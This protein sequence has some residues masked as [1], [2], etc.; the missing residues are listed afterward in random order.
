MKL[1]LKRRHCHLLTLLP[2]RKMMMRKFDIFLDLLFCLLSIFWICFSTMIG[3]FSF[4]YIGVLVKTIWSPVAFL[5]VINRVNV[6]FLNYIYTTIILY[7]TTKSDRWLYIYTTI[8]LY[9]T[10]EWWSLWLHWSIYRD[11]TS[12]MV[13]SH[14]V[15]CFLWR[16]VEAEAAWSS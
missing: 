1:I 4:Y 3:F 8:I 15:W 14:G 16:L 5:F 6:A 13:D 9:T 7:T 2:M 12:L 10:S 11:K